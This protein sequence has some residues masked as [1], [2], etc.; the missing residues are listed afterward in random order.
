MSK[1]Q[2][3]HTQ[4][5]SKKLIGFTFKLFLSGNKFGFAGKIWSCLSANITIHNIVTGI[6][7]D[8]ENKLHRKKS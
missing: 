1:K 7:N 3:L 6:I 2:N 4:F 5:F 8:T